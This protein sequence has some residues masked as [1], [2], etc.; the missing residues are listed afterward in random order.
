MH[1]QATT[2]DCW[3]QR[4]ATPSVQ[5]LSFEQPVVPGLVQTATGCNVQDVV[6]VGRWNLGVDNRAGRHPAVIGP[7][8]SP[9]P[10]GPPGP[11]RPVE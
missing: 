9:E 7:P 5:S 6:G 1:E 8:G 4:P 2:P 3:V 11:D 10:S